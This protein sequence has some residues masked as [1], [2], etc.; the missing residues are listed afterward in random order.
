VSSAAERS[1]QVLVQASLVEENEENQSNYSQDV[2]NGMTSCQQQVRTLVDRFGQEAVLENVALVI[3]LERIV[4]L[5]AERNGR[6]QT[7]KCATRP[8][9]FPANLATI[10]VHGRNIKIVR[11]LTNSGTIWHEADADGFLTSSCS[12]MFISVFV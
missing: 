6:E 4:K 1:E 8:P 9:T 10:P 11:E 3:G 7:K 2:P 12:F 5:L